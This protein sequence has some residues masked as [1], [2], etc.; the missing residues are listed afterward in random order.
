MEK[1][2]W[3]CSV[4]TSL[5]LEIE[6]FA[7]ARLISWFRRK[8]RK[9]IRKQWNLLINA[10]FI[11][12]F[13]LY[14]QPPFVSFFLL[15]ALLQC[16]GFLLYLLGL[17]FPKLSF[18]FLNIYI[19]CL[20]KAITTISIKKTNKKPFLAIQALFGCCFGP[21]NRFFHLLQGVFCSY[22]ATLL[23]IH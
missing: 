11:S 18:R 6:N 13:S 16:V 20:Y 7:I 14:H 8:K 21:L 17:S 5:V 22:V 3:T 1:M 2:G 19:L 9:K 10:F 4:F 15:E 23:A 12:F